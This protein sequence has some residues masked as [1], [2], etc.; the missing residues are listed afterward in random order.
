L[1][2]LEKNKENDLPSGW[3]STQLENVVEIL[4]GKR[5][6][7][8]SKEREKRKGTIPYYG[9]TG[10]VGWIDDYL[11][12]EE[13]VLLGEDGAPFLEPLKNKAYLIHGKSWVNN[14]A[15]VLRGVDGIVLNKYFCHY[16]NQFG[17]HEFISGTT[18]MKLNQSSM[19][20][21]PIS[22]SPLN[23]QKRIVVKIE[24][25][26]SNIDNY[27]SILKQILLKLRQLQNSF[28]V[29]A[30]SGTLTQKWRRDNTV[31]SAKM[32][33]QKIISNR[34]EQASKVSDKKTKKQLIK[35]AEISVIGV[36]PKIKSWLDIKLKNLVYIAGRIGWKGLKAEE[37]TENGPL[38]LSVYQLNDGG[39]VNFENS[40]HI[41]KERYVESPEIQLQNNDILLVKDGSGI[42][43]ISIVQDLKEPATVNS[44]L[45]VIRSGE[46]FIPKF[47]FYFLYGPELQNIAQQRITGSATPHL[48]QRDIKKFILSMPPLEEQIE[49]VK[50]I[51]NG[52]TTIQNTHKIILNELKRVNNIK[53]LILQIA[54]E[55][56]LVPQDPNDEPA[57]KLLKRI[58]ASDS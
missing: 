37:Y 39:I 16:L 58:K 41:S 22:I 53:N 9:A 13:L 55:G 15:H 57:E 5:I 24:E 27:D 38:F 20:K 32:L 23:E 40:Y 50:L 48:F 1:L 51:D 26:F 21:I 46:A 6:P 45:L 29:S 14:H 52:L 47:L 54:F 36:N 18:R 4:D 12:N 35:R 42:G 30:F 44:S 2:V 49:I 33:I 31:N 19:R 34:L 56:K 28:L 43:K 3:V 25:L 11:F 7:I 10:Q 17:Y 8:N